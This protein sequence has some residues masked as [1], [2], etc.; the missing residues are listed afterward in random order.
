MGGVCV[1]GGEVEGV[2]TTLVAG[3][4]HT[5]G[6][7]PA[8]KYLFFNE[9]N[10][11][12]NHEVLHTDGATKTRYLHTSTTAMA[13]STFSAE[14]MDLYSRQIGAFGM[15]TMMKLVRPPRTQ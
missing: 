9:T 3:L 7:N 11:F 4:A 10:I 14:E 5:A 6:C 13:E 2:S 15:E 1:G 8:A 12:I